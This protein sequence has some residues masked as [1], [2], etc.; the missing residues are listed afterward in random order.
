[1]YTVLYVDEY[2]AW[3]TYIDMYD[4]IPSSTQ[5]YLKSESSVL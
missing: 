5:G 1:M 2:A 3:T 4:R